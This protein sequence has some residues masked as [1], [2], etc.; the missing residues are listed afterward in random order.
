MVGADV[1]DDQEDEEKT[2][3]T[4]IVTLWRFIDL[5][6]LYTPHCREWSALTS[7]KK[8]L[9][10]TQPFDLGVATTIHERL[11]KIDDSIQEDNE[12]LALLTKWTHDKLQQGGDDEVCAILS[13]SS[14][15]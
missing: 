9:V 11:D 3:A 4:L 5:G 1:I 2:M 7:G 13:E 14:T 6:S 15:G 12:A 10:E 8:T